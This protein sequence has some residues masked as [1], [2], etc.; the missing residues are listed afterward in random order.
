MPREGIFLAFVFI[1]NLF[2]A[3]H[4]TKNACAF[5]M[6]G[7]VLERQQLY[8]GA[9]EA[10]EEALKLLDVN[11]E[12]YTLHD[13][14]H[15]NYGRVLVQLQHYEDALQQYQEVKKADFVTQC[16]VAVAYFKGKTYILL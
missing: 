6:L 3:A 11:G 9:V 10:F 13:M 5:N 12:D 16:G 8:Q 1:W 4:I 2:H 14:V 7:L 15:S